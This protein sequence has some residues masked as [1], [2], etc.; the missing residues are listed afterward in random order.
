MRVEPLVLNDTNVVNNIN[1]S[2]T[3]RRWVKNELDIRLRLCSYVVI[4]QLFRKK[5]EKFVIFCFSNTFE[6]FI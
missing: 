2:K 4:E 1:Y 3:N 6:N 5:T